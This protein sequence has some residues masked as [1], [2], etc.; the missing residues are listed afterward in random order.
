[1]AARSGRRRQQDA[2]FTLVLFIWALALMAIMMGVAVQTVSF[3]MQRERETELI[4]RGQ[5][6]VEAIRLYKLKF[7][8]N[9]MQLKELWEAKPRVL[10]Q[11][12]VDPMTGSE[13]WGIV[14]LGQ[15]GNTIGGPGTGP[16]GG[17]K[18]PSPSPS[19]GS[20]GRFGGGS[21][22]RGTLG[23]EPVK[24]GPIIGVHSKSC[25]ES[26]RTFEGRSTYCEWRFVLQEGRR[27][28]GHGGGGGT[29]GGGTGGGTSGGGTSG[30]GT[31]GGGTFG[32]GG[33]SS[34]G[35]SRGGN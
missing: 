17:N 8:R 27:T 12:W 1:M 16:G 24:V 28:R 9:P 35:G 19:P 18:T 22:G 25:E 32:G 15:E 26:I 13:E 10:R 11:K 4:F 7:G 23:R 5:Q 14:F 21:G 29:G 2:G 34:R 33:G 31:S 30:G 6:Y 20:G 3:Q